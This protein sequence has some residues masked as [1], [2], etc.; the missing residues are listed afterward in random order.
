MTRRE[1]AAGAA[2]LALSA[3]ASADPLK[4]PE[5]KLPAAVKA[6][7]V[8]ARRGLELCEKPN[9]GAEPVPE[10]VRLWSRRV[11]DAEFA[12]SSA[13]PVE[14]LAAVEAYLRHAR[15][16]EKSVRAAFDQG[17]G[18]MAAVLDAE[19]HRADAETLLA[20]EKAQQ[21]G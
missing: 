6:R 2:V 17:A 20:E 18:T 21:A 15:A 5:P 1:L 19:Y 11:V 3:A 13:R 14:R 4:T 8:A 16:A 12:L 7:L 9:G 10:L